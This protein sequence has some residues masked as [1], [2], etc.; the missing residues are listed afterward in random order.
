[1]VF[2]PNPYDPRVVMLEDANKTDTII[3]VDL[4]GNDE[5][6]DGSSARPYQS[7][8]RAFQDISVR[9]QVK[10]TIQLGAGT[11]TFPTELQNA[12]VASFIDI[13]GST[14]TVEA[15][16][17][18]NTVVSNTAS[19]GSEITVTGTP[20]TPGDLVGRIV[21]FTSG[22]LNNR[23][24]IVYENTNNSIKF[25]QSGNGFQA[26]NVGDAFDLWD[27]LPTILDLVTTTGAPL[28]PSSDGYIYM[29]G[30]KLSFQEVAIT[31]GDNSTLSGQLCIIEY[32]R[33]HLTTDILSS[34]NGSFIEFDNSYIIPRSGATF[35]AAASENCTLMTRN[36]SVL[37][38][39]NNAYIL[40]RHLSV[41]R[42]RGE[43]VIARL[44]N[45]GIQVQGVYASP[46][47]SDSILRLVSCA[48]G[49]HTRRD[50]VVTTDPLSG[51]SIIRLHGFYGGVTSNYMIE[52]SF[53][54]KYLLD[55]STTTV[56]TNTVNNACSTDNGTSESYY[57]YREGTAIIGTNN[58]DEIELGQDATTISV[59]AGGTADNCVVRTNATNTVL[60]TIT[61]FTNGFPGQVIYVSGK[62]GAN[63]HQILDGG[64]FEL[65]GGAAWQA[66]N[67]ALIALLYEENGAGAA[68]W[69]ELFRRGP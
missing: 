24:G 25:T 64:N 6:G 30:S 49:F 38:G 50:V 3:N 27:P 10:Y 36:G 12:G 51:G 17:T 47:R 52:A 23:Y 55:N 35:V 39:G 8:V 60:T 1:M 45:S 57:N 5:S 28:S 32:L 41:W 26:V 34:T 11:F 44:S 4:S 62:G 9:A 13:V 14:P 65:V 48:K 37:D 15:S 33:C 18:V 59:I 31:T 20:W 61:N 66:N 19:A 58:D 54:D 21:R 22:N 43:V 46:D 53:G 67:D 69:K 7:I 2:R 42:M 68:R 40:F 63:L 16:H 29:A 56:T